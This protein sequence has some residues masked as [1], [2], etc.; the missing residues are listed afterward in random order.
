[1]EPSA[2]FKELR[3]LLDLDLEYDRFCEVW[4]SVLLPDP[5]LPDSL[6]RELKKRGY[7]VLAL[8]NTN[9]IHYPAIR[10]R[11][12]ALKWFDGAVLS[13]Q[14]GALK[15]SAEIYKAAV[16]AAGCDP[17][18]CFFTDD[19]PTYVDGARRAGIDAVQ[20][21]S[22]GQLMNELRVRGMLV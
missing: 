1:M 15:P 2:F 6:F 19:S 4:T 8:S 16:E 20:F 11:Y 5:I 14:V 13:Y 10:V 22:P 12:P 7:R 9:A 21:L 3:A 17:A 18:E